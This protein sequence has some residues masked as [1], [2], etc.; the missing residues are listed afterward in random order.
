MS[1]TQNK[2][3][4]NNICLYKNNQPLDIDID[5]I[6]DELYAVADNKQKFKEIMD[7][8]EKDVLS[9]DIDPPKRN[10]NNYYSSNKKNNTIIKSTVPQGEL[11]KY[12]TYQTKILH[13]KY[14]DVNANT[15]FYYPSQNINKL[16]PNKSTWTNRANQ[17]LLNS[18]TNFYNVNDTNNTINTAGKSTYTNFYS[19]FK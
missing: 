11:L 8:L 19:S 3:I 5:V 2:F 10:I 4:Y 6:C 17:I 7:K 15:K 9:S 1:N 13:K 18:N 14:T 16:E 12:P